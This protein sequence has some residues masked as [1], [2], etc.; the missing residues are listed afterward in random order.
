MIRRN[1]VRNY[2]ILCLFTMAYI[3]L[4]QAN[5]MIESDLYGAVKRARSEGKF[6]IAQ[7][8]TDWC[9]QC[10]IIH[11]DSPDQLISSDV[12][13]NYILV[14][15]NIDQYRG[16]QLKNQFEINKL[17]TLLIFGSDGRLH[18]RIEQRL[19]PD[20]L[21]K[22]LHRTME[23]NQPVLH[24]QNISPSHVFQQETPQ[25]TGK[26]NKKASTSGKERTFQLQL[27]VY[28][29]FERTK[30]IVDELKNV[31][32][33]SIIIQHDY[34]GNTVIYRILTG[35]FSKLSEA[36]TYRKQL[37]EVHGIESFIHM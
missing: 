8:Y 10:E 28:S 7:F 34:K 15:V 25:D 23:R 35:H 26:Q 29:S 9:S 5:H 24:E 20:E 19:N 36:E 13:D 17:P 2:L 1:Q 6:V 31:V 14:H 18:A 16:F 27:G 12:K 22:V 4:L 37:K 32:P 21:S 30:K 3:P 11:P 33:D